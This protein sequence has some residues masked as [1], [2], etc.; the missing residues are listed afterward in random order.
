MIYN[1]PN[2][3]K[4]ASFNEE[5]HPSTYKNAAD[6]LREL[7]GGH[8]NRANE[9]ERWSKISN[10]RNKPTFKLNANLVRIFN[11]RLNKYLEGLYLSP[12]GLHN[13]QSIEKSG[14][15]DC[16]YVGF[17]IWVNEERDDFIESGAD[18]E[19]I[20]LIILNLWFTDVEYCNDDLYNAFNINFFFKKEKDDEGDLLK[21][22]HVK[23]DKGWNDYDSKT[24]FFDRANA[25]KFKNEVLKKLNIE[26]NQS[27]KEFFQSFSTS[28]EYKK[29]HEYIKNISANLL[30]N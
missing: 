3:K 6:K 25:N 15:I 30:W 1:K 13:N 11:Q 8:V 19:K 24:L 9:L 26:K 4:F 17:D 29:L 22:S 16:Y 2:I 27:V 5:L 18:I 14:P 23:V 21:I 12:F 28:E 7:G 10:Y 20:P